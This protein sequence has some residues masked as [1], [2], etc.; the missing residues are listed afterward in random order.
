MADTKSL[1]EQDNPLADTQDDQ[2]T[3]QVLNLGR[4][5]L[6]Q[7]FQ[8]K[9][10]HICKMKN[11]GISAPSGF[12][13]V[14]EVNVGKNFALAD[15]FFMKFSTEEDVRFVLVLGKLDVMMNSKYS[16]LVEFVKPARTEATRAAYRRIYQINERLPDIGREF[17]SMG[18]IREEFADKPQLSGYYMSKAEFKV[19][20]SRMEKKRKAG[21]NLSAFDMSVLKRTRIVDTDKLNARID[22]LYNE[23]QDAWLELGKYKMMGLDEFGM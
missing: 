3:V 5:V 22:E 2:L 9:F 15:E 23:E 12:R 20:I 4:Y 16:R 7:T 8:E 13:I 10:E 14:V 18:A 11:I 21:E 6:A 19:I 1:G 17:K